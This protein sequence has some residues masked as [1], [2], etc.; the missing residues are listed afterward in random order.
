MT[1]FSS[2]IRFTLNASRS[3]NCNIF[4][5]IGRREASFVKREATEFFTML[6]R[7]ILMAFLRFALN[8]DPLKIGTGLFRDKAGSVSQGLLFK[9]LKIF[10]FSCPAYCLLHTAY[11]VF[12][13]A[14][15]IGHFSYQP[16]RF[17]YQWSRFRYQW[18]SFCYQWK[19]FSYQ[20][21]KF[22]P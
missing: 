21:D 16:A 5:I 20:W 10:F 7:W 12:R 4:T 9:I 14:P 1:L 18:N 2:E 3:K 17:S 11:C 8:R 6:T 22:C 19:R 15:Q 13:I